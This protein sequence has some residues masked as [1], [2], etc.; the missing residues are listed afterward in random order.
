M[1]IYLAIYTHNYGADYAVFSTKEKAVEWG[2]EIGKSY[3]ADASNEDPPTEDIG[4]KYFEMIEFEWFNIE[5]LELDKI[6]AIAPD[7]EFDWGITAREA[8][9]AAK[10]K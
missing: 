2:N 7:Q 9:E 10:D 1:K 5:E 6:I 3:W 4:D 8:L